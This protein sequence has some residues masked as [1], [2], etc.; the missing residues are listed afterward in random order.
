MTGM[1]FLACLWTLFIVQTG[2]VRSNVKF[3]E[4]HEGESVVLPC[5]YDQSYPLPYGVHLKRSWQK[6]PNVLFK[7]D[8]FDLTV[9][10]DD[11][12]NRISVSG[13]LN[14]RSL[15]V[16]ISQL[17]VS[18][19]DRYY[20]EFVVNVPS[21]EDQRIP[22]QT[23]FF[24]LVSA[25]A[26]GSVDIGLVETCAGGSAVLPCH[27]PNGEGLAV[28]GVSLKRQKSLAPVEIL[29]HSKRQYGSSP[30]SSSSPSSQFTS[31]RVQL[32]SAPGPGGI[33]YNLTLR[34]LQPEDSALYSCQLLVSGRAET[35]ASL[36]RRVFF[37]SVQGRHCSCFDYSTLLYT[38]SA[39]VAVLLVF[40]LIGLV[41]FYKGKKKS[42][43]SQ[44]H[45]PI[46]EEMS[47]LQPPRRKLAP[48][49]LEEMESSEYRNCP[50]KKSCTENHYESPSG[51][52]SPRN[53]GS[54]AS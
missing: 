44:G 45:A 31:E 2:S 11:D 18:D 15:N 13:N 47:G 40:A 14:S 24:L 20:C 22:G 19:T 27:P 49:H 16:T 6:P 53:L 39:A 43:K 4:R 25:D 21:A 33:T 35:I 36:G 26:H 51:A 38:V 54:S 1:Q 8:D 32:S 12:K 46:Y 41:K 48:C 30:P 42:V 7:D 52:L 37:V 28:E 29:Y 9:A 17:R 3:L 50:V 34:Q 5:V 10:N 23:E